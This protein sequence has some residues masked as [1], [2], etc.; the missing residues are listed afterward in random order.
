MKTIKKH[1]WFWAHR[2]NATLHH[3]SL[4]IPGLAGDAW[5]PVVDFTIQHAIAVHE[6]GKGMYL[7]YD[8][9]ELS[10]AGVYPKIEQSI[11]QNEH[12]V[13]DFQR[14]TDEL[15]GA[16]FF[17]IKHIREANIEL[18]T[19]T[20][21]ATLWE[22]YRHALTVG[23]LIT[24]QLWGIEALFD[25]H[26]TLMRWL[27][28][29][30]S[31]HGRIAELQQYRELLAINMG[32]TIA[33]TEQ[34]QLL[35]ILA[36]IDTKDIRTL[37][38]ELTGIELKQ[39]LEERYP[40]AFARIQSHAETFDW[41]HKEYRSEGWS[42]LEWLDLIQKELTH[43]ETPRQRLA[44]FEHEFKERCANQKKKLE[45]LTPP[46]DVRHLM[47]G[48]STLI[49]QR[50]ATKG[51]FAQTLSVYHKLLTEIG[52][53]YNLTL[54]DLFVYTQDDMR[55]LLADSLI[56][57]VDEVARRKTTRSVLV[58]EHGSYT[59]LTEPSHVAKV[60]DVQH[61]LE[62]L[63]AATNT[64]ELKGLG[65]SRGVVRGKVRVLENTSDLQRLAPGE[66]LV[67]YMTTV[68]FTP[69]F[70]L[71]A[72]VVTDEGGMAC[73]AA[74]TSREYGIPAVVG[75]QTAT[76]VLQTGDIVE[77]DGAKGIVKIMA[78]RIYE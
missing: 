53:R 76:R 37:I 18:A 66:I 59:L 28:E 75:T 27:Y 56:V 74:I 29:Y 50:D 17:Q 71:A 78:P 44:N 63:Q 24:V 5:K 11:I 4:L 20:E 54:Q 77:I 21:L 51:Y 19:N 46:K 40:D 57:T 16:L 61:L 6:P 23:P 55:A 69:A 52:K 3:F 26:G 13:Q 67:T 36:T 15:F 34:K 45:Q 39:A 47:A 64:S 70:R 73:H 2:R 38:N 58:C 30:L 14:R 33:Y 1:T 72:A 62:P 42:L 48:L 68:E 60:I 25:P 65:A 10:Q 22:G 49:A 7:F 9:N 31:K 35:R 43:K 32:E 8:R 12:F 41:V